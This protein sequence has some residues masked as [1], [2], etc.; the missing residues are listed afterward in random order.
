LL[1][2]RI[3]SLGI[4]EDAQIAATKLSD[5]CFQS[6]FVSFTH[7]G[8]RQVKVVIAYR[9]AT[10]NIQRARCLSKRVPLRN[11]TSLS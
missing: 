7:L 1:V 9:S 3:D 11:S 4:Y 5:L 2:V 10:Y 8:L 6:C